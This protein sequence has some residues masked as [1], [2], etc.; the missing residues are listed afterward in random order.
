[1]K[2]CRRPPRGRS[3]RGRRP[4]LHHSHLIPSVLVS[5][6]PSNP[7]AVL[8]LKAI[9]GGSGTGRSPP[10]G[11]RVATAGYDGTARV[12]DARTGAELS[13]LR[14]VTAGDNPPLSFSPDGTRVAGVG[15][16]A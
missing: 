5:K 2:P 10:D 16:G 12:W 14:G 9:R 4:G 8:L 3:D 6:E 11:S 1:M 15:G 7:S 13:A